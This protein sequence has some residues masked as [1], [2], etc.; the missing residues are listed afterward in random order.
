MASPSPVISLPA[1][2][3]PAAAVNKTITLPNG[4]TVPVIFASTETAAVFKGTVTAEISQF[5][6][7]SGGFAVAKD[8]SKLTIAAAGVTAFVGTGNLGVRVTDGKL[9]V[10]VKTDTK[11]FAAVAS[12]TAALEGVDGLTVTGTGSVRINKLGTAIDETISTPSGDVTVKFDNGTDILQVRGTLNLQFQNFVYASGDFLLEKTQ[13]SDLTTITL[14]ASNLNA[15]LGVNYGV[16]GEFGVKVTGAGV[17][18]LIEKQGSNAAKYAISTTGGTAGLVGLSGVDLTGPLA[19]NINKL[20]RTIATNIP[21]PSGTT[22]PLNFTDPAPV[23]RFGGDINLNIAGFTTLTGTYGFEIETA[24]GATEIRVAGTNINA[25]LG[26]NPDG[27]IGNTD[28]VGARISSAKLAQ[29]S[30]ARLPVRHPTRSTRRARHLWSVSM[31]S[32]S[33]VTSLLELTPLA[34]PSTKPS[35]CPTAKR[36]R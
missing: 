14:A 3:P 2:T 7:I 18:M 16:T 5:A 27:I 24:S 12:G 33:P 10:V 25:V 22:I 13:V 28:D 4:E 6:S 15:F 30:S 20:G 26:S 34:A 19:L 32:P 21:A 11:K 17:A 8:G 1:S 29:S 31:A 9:G 23:Q 35:R 36:C